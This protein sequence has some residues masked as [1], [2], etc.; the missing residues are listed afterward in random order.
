MEM[1]RILAVDDMPPILSTLRIFLRG[2]FHL[3]PVNSA[4][5]AAQLLEKGD[6]EFD[7]IL[8]D[9]DMPVMSGFELLKKIKSNPKLQAVP[10]VMLTGRVD[11]NS[12]LEA[13]SSGAA[14]YIVKPFTE[15]I[16][17]KKIRAVLKQAA[18]STG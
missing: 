18:R 9:V 16:L 4:T 12:V 5:E 10:V 17:K 13:I 7:L 15:D 14:D 8:L 1:K 3:H 11:S 2:E 6:L